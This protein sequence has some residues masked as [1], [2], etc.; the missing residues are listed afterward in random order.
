MAALVSFRAIVIE[1]IIDLAV[2]KDAMSGSI[3][4]NSLLDMG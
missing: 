2:I 1:L 3:N 4:D